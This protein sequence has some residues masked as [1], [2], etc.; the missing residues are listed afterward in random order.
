MS[1][2]KDIALSEKGKK[3]IDWAWQFM[4]VLQSLQKEFNEEKPLKGRRIGACLHVTT[5]TANLMRVLKAGGAQ[6]SLCA[7]NPLSTQDDTA[8]SLVHDFDVEVFAINGED[9][10]VYY[11]HLNQV[12]DFKPQITMDDGA[13]LVSL[14][15][16]ERPEQL[17]EV[18]GSSEETTTGVIR[19]KAMANEGKLRIPVVAVNDSATK[20]MFDNRYGTGQSTI[21]GILRATN[22]LLAGSVFV[23]CGYGWCGR[24]IAMRAKGMGAIVT[25]CEVD[26][27]R[28]LEAAM[29]G[30]SVNCLS[31]AISQADVVVTSTGNKHVVDEEHFTQAKDA[32]I[33]ANAGHF[34][35]EINKVALE[36]LSK[37]VIEVRDG[38]TLYELKDGKKIYLLTEG[39]LVNLAAAAGH[40]A[41]VMDMS[42]ANQALAAKY[43]ID[44]QGKLEGKVYRLPQEIDDDIARLKLKAMGIEID[45]L[46][47]EQE[48]YLKSW[49]EGT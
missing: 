11:Q 14:L 26:S 25:V 17:D 3:K 49:R 1:D 21:D 34:D 18:M 44:H 9:R 48:K 6:V 33:L 47:A 41:E 7:S 46:T 43:F 32:V 39:R 37:R 16:Q 15:H 19:L 40:P 42:F 13:D 45:K 38:V 20:Y 10:D 30:F 29:D 35:V 12:L 4:P 2:V 28:A 31:K 36:R 22:K 8:A 5:E 24:G 23:V 27:I